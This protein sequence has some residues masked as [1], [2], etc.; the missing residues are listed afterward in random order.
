MRAA[1]IRKALYAKAVAEDQQRLADLL[2]FETEH[3]LVAIRELVAQSLVIRPDHQPVHAYAAV[4]GIRARIDAAAREAC[5]HDASLGRETGVERLGHGAELRHE[6][7]GHAGCDRQGM[8]GLL[9]RE[10]EDARRR[11]RGADRAD[12]R[13]WRASPRCGAPGSPLPYAP[14]DLEAGDIGV[15]A[16]R[17]RGAFLLRQSKDRGDQHRGRVRLSW[18]EIVVEVERMRG[19]AVD[20]GG[21][22]GSQRHAGPIALHGPEPQAATVAKTRRTAPS[23]APRSATPAMST[24]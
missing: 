12:R 14:E 13:R 15:D 4:Q 23:T 16:V 24:N 19:R 21:P 1:A 2:G 6:P 3:R 11:G 20:E 9:R 22:R 5:G 7:A 8:A 18:I 17:A 10:G